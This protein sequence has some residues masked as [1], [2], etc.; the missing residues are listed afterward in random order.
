[1]C[2]Y[3]KAFDATP[4]GGGR[5]VC[6]W[7]YVCVWMWKAFEATPTGVRGRRCVCVCEKSSVASP[8]GWEEPLVCVDVKAFTPP[9][10]GEEKDP[11]VCVCVGVENRSWLPPPGS[12][13]DVCVGENAF[14]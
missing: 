10:T 12:V 2:G 4:E 5:D 1:M 11:C 6:G 14:G 8:R 3:G 13:G 9:P 7:V